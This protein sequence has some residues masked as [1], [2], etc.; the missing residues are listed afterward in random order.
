MLQMAPLASFNAAS[1]C[2]GCFLDKNSKL[3]LS[4]QMTSKH[5]DWARRVNSHSVMFLSADRLS[6]QLLLQAEQLLLSMEKFLMRKETSIGVS[7]VLVSVERR[8]QT[9]QRIKSPV[10]T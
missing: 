8:G 5:T 9:F 2:F 3:W 10:R 7:E 1:L 6:E 4:Q